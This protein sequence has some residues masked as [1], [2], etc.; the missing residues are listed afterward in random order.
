MPHHLGAK[1][2]LGLGFWP[3]PEDDP[4]VS[5]GRES[6]RLVTPDGALVRGLLWT[7]PAGTPWKTA[8][9][10][11]HPRG[12]FS[13]HMPKNLPGAAAE[14]AREINEVIDLAGRMTDELVETNHTVGRDGKLGRRAAVEGATG[15]WKACVESCNTVINALAQRTSECQ[16]RRL[17]HPRMGTIARSRVA[18]GQATHQA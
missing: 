17:G 13:V 11:S 1:R 12:D 6:V 9:I 7:P 14:V 16:R 10:L 3:L 4:G 15:K 18:A 2:P 5:V 8:V